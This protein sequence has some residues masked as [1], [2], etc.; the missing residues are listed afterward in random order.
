[1]NDLP[2]LILD[3]LHA[4]RQQLLLQHGGV[5][6]LAAFLRQE[7]AKCTTSIVEPGSNPRSDVTDHPGR[8]HRAIRG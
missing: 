3:K 1:M 8:S 5:A 6:G 7:E 4:T 2:D